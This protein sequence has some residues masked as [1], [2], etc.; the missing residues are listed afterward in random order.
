VTI[1]GLNKNDPVIRAIAGTFQAFKSFIDPSKLSETSKFD[2][3]T[4]DTPKDPSPVANSG[5]GSDGVTTRLGLS[6]NINIVL[7]V[8][9]DPNV[10]N[11]IF[12][13]LKDNLLK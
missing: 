1:T 10:L 3:L 7:P 11:A 5:S 9:D 13:S 6:Y 8:T 2:P 12:R 4:D